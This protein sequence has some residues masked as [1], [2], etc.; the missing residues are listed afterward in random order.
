MITFYRRMYYGYFLS[1]KEKGRSV[2]EA[3]V[4]I[5]VGMSR[6]VFYTIILFFL[7]YYGVFSLTRENVWY[8]VIFFVLFEVLLSNFLYGKSKLERIKKDFDSLSENKQNLYKK[9]ATVITPISVILSIGV[10]YFT[11]GVG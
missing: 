1:L 5:F 9:V 10:L 3:D 11:Y 8:A 2:N 6:F 4:S 7:R